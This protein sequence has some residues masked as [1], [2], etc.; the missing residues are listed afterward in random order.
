MFNETLLEQGYA[1]VYIIS[2]N[3]KYED[4]FEEAQDEAQAAERGVWALSASEQSLSWRTGT[5]QSA[6]AVAPRRPPP[7]PRPHRSRR[8]S[9]R[10]SPPRG[11]Y[12]RYVLPLH[13]DKH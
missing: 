10:N 11:R 9:R 12:R 6:V 4:R 8:S 13:R 7:R 5:M 3:D 2:P 1:Q